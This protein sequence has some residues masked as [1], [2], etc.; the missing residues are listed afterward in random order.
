M[1]NCKLV[2]STCMYTNESWLTSL[3]LKRR[4]IGLSPSNE[5]VAQ[6]LP[7]LYIRSFVSCTRS[8]HQGCQMVY[9]K[10][11]KSQLG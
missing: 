2:I 8:H 4:F 7:M 3:T 6:G 10:N 1:Y 5:K 11:Q 9:F